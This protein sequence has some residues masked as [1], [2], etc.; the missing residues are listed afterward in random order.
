M[1]ATLMQERKKFAVT[2]TDLF[3]T[4]LSLSGGNSSLLLFL[5]CEMTLLA[6]TVAL[7]WSSWDLR[8]SPHT[9]R[10]YVVWCS[11]EPQQTAAPEG[12]V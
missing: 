11:G 12:S 9:G 10:L 2:Q 3:Y 4:V 8:F 5:F 7:T 6:Q 1:I